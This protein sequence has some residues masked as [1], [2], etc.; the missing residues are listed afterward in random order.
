MRIIGAADMTGRIKRL[1]AEK[2]AVTIPGSSIENLHGAADMT[3]RIKR[4]SA[5][6]PAV[7]IPGSSIENLDW[8]R[9][10]HRCHYS[11]RDI[12]LGPEE[13]A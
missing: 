10:C 13:T 5:E 8:L 7:T 1:S 3:G 4:L 6:K 11:C 12:L 2:P 9:A